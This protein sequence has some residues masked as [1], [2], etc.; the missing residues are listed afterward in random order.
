MSKLSRPSPARCEQAD[1]SHSDMRVCPDRC[2]R[3]IRRLHWACPRCF[4]ERPRSPPVSTCGSEGARRWHGC[5]SVSPQRRTRG[6]TR[7]RFSMA[8]TA[9][10]ARWTSLDKVREVRRRVQAASVL[11]GK[12]CR[13]IHWTSNQL[14]SLIACQFSFCHLSSRT[15]EQTR[16]KHL[17]RRVTYGL[18]PCSFWRSLRWVPAA[19]V[20]PTACYLCIWRGQGQAGL[21]WTGSPGNALVTPRILCFWDKNSNLSNSICSRAT[22]FFSYVRKCIIYQL[23]RDTR[24]V[25]YFKCIKWWIL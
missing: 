18:F 10:N 24:T 6:N 17:G 20:R 7:L 15:S 3:K 1:P 23:P 25:G 21:F 14:I 8:K 16:I 9:T 4:L 5:R 12:G 2:E 11:K 13:I 19:Q 22:I